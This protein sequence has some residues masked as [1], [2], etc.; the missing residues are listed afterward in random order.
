MGRAFLLDCRIEPALWPELE[1][2]FEERGICRKVN[3]DG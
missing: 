3:I 2:V 1:R